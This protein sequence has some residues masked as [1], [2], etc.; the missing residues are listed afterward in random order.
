LTSDLPTDQPKPADRNIQNQDPVTLRA[1]VTKTSDQAKPPD[2]S[3]DP[4]GLPSSL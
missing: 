3:R 1:F 4:P 2:R